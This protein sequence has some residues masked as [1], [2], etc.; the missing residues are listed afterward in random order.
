MTNYLRSLRS[1]QLT[2]GSPEVTDLT[3]G[4]AQGA[5]TQADDEAEAEDTMTQA[6]TLEQRRKKRA[7]SDVEDLGS[8]QDVEEL[9]SRTLFAKRQKQCERYTGLLPPRWTIY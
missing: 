4:S 1:A 2:T 5:S 9:E 6:S 7:L 8:E 3:E